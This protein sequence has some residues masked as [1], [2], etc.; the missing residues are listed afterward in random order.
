ML[1]V[2]APEHFGDVGHPHRHA[3]MPGVGF[4]DRIHREDADRVGEFGTSGHERGAAPVSAFGSG[5]R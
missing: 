1:Q 3:G 5:I 4:L 2:M